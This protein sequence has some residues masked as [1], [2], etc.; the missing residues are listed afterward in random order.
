M[1]DYRECL[2]LSSIELLTADGAESPVIEIEN[3]FVR[4][5]H[6]IWEK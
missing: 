1:V 2:Q 4:F 5:Y 6:E 3:K